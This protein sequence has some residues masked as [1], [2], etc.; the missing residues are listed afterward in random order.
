M[1]SQNQ[2]PF[3]SMKILTKKTIFLFCLHEIFRFHS[4]A[5]QVFFL[6][7]NA[8][9]VI[10]FA[11]KIVLQNIY[12][13]TSVKNLPDFG[14]KLAKT[15]QIIF[16]IFSFSYFYSLIH[17]AMYFQQCVE[18]SSPS[19]IISFED[20]LFWEFHSDITFEAVIY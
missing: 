12:G 5:L 14:Q 11:E 19:K 9:F 18:I 8:I 15:R 20:F 2:L 16:K 13:F 4:L 7:K 6:S 17:S 3:Y 10:I 1:K